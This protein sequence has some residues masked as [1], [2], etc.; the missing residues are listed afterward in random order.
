MSENACFVKCF[1]FSPVPYLNLIFTLS[2]NIYISLRKLYVTCNFKRI[3]KYLKKLRGI[4]LEIQL[5]S[6]NS[7]NTH[8]KFMKILI[9]V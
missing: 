5:S 1:F 9:C 4:I 7:I 6:H 3:K 2:I 8:K